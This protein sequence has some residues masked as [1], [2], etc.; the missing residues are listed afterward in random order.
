MKETTKQ[1]GDHGESLASTFLQKKGYEILESN[2]RFRRAEID[3]IAQQGQFLVFIEVKL[4]KNTSFGNPEDVV[5][6]KKI[7]LIQSAAENFLETINWVGP[8]RFD[9]I[10]ISGTN[11]E[12]EHFEDCF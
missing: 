8:I 1:I 10:S 3:L 6:D 11:T 4:R 2:F 12:I 5:N 9:I 7:E